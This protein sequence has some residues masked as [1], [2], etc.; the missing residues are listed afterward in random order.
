[1]IEIFDNIAEYKSLRKLLFVY[2]SISLFP[3]LMNHD[4]IYY[5]S[6]VSADDGSPFD[7]IS[8]YS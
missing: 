4:P 1:M 2:S 3:L 7:P 5:P 6:Y 8:C